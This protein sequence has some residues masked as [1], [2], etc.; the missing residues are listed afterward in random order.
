ML[1][2][3]KF[4]KIHLGREYFRW[5]ETNT[6]THTYTHRARARARVCYTNSKTDPDLTR[7]I[8]PLPS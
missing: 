8:V 2:F 5:R 3:E 6:H 7:K 4:G 1:F